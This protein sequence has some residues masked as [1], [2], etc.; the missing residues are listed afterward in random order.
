MANYNV[1]CRVGLGK[2]RTAVFEVNGSATAIGTTSSNPLDVNSGDTITFRRTTNSGGDAQVSELNNFTNNASMVLTIS[3]PNVTRTTSTAGLDTVK[4][5]NA[6]GA[7]TEI[8]YYYINVQSVNSGPNSFN[9]PNIVNASLST[10]YESSSVQMTGITGTLTASVSGQG[11]PQLEVN[12]SGTWTTSASITNNQYLKIRLTSPSGN[13]QT[14]TA[15]VTVGGRSDTVTI[16]TIPTSGQGTDTGSASAAYGL[17]VYD[18]NGST[19]VLSPSTRYITLMQEPSAVTISAG[20]TTTVLQDMTGLTSSNSTLTFLDWANLVVTVS[21][22]SNGF[23][24]TNSFSSGSYTV[25]PLIV[26]F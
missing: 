9:I 1:D 11:S 19:K 8:D 3:A 13:S 15:T 2:G 24:L 12:N 18:V 25:Y 20:V 26:R 14:H 16:T 17:E 7:G 6:G 5:V 10:Q 22:V 4:L 23:Q 21:R